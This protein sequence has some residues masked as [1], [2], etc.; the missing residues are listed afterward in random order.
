MDAILKVAEGKMGGVH[1]KA[2]TVT[3]ADPPAATVAESKQVKLKLCDL[4]KIA[5]KTLE[6][7][8]NLPNVPTG[9]FDGF[10]TA[11]DE[12]FLREAIDSMRKNHIELN[13]L[14]CELEHLELTQKNLTRAIQ[15][16][17]NSIKSEMKKCVADE[18]KERDCSGCKSCVK[19]A[20]EKKKSAPKKKKSTKKKST[21]KKAHKHKHKH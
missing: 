18:C 2:V 11:C 17:G 3:K 4:I 13:N 12:N 10:S 5:D 7:I 8:K 14:K 21:K 20:Q 1:K 9:C 6:N 15:H 19:K 16:C